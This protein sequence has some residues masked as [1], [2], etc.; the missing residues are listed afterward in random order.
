MAISFVFSDIL[1]YV[2][3]YYVYHGSFIM[4]DRILHVIGLYFLFN[5]I[6]EYNKVPKIQVD[7]EEKFVTKNILV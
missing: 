5:Y 1:N 7:K 4:L 3:Q 6:I 2:S